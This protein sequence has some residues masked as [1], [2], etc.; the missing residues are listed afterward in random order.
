MNREFLELYNR[1]LGILKEE[2]RQFAA[3]FPGVAERLGGLLEN[4]TDP[5]IAGLL[6]GTAYLASRVQLKLKH[7]YAEFTDNLLDQLV[8]DYLAPVPSAALLRVEP[9]YGDPNLKDGMKIAAGSYADARFVERERRIACKYRLASEIT[10]WPFELGQAEFLSGPATLQALGIEAGP[11]SQAGLRLSLLRRSAADR[12]TEPADKQVA[13][14]PDCWFANCRTDELTFH[15]IG[16]EGDAVRLY[17]QLFGATTGIYVRYLDEAGDP[18]ILPLP[19]SCLAQIGFA[20]DE[21]LFPSDRRVFRGFDLLR[22]YFVLPAKFLGFKLTNLKPVLSAI[23]TNRCDIV[24]AFSQGDS[25]LQSVVRADSFALYAAAASNLFEMQLARVPVKDNEHEYHVVT[26]RSRHLDFEAHRLIRMHAHVTGSGDKMEVYPLYAAPPLGVS[27]TQTM[28]YTVRRLPRRRSQEER[29]NAQ[30][31]QY[32]GSDMFVTLTNHRDRPDGLHVAELSLRA[33]CSNRHLT[34]HLPVGQGGADFILEDKT[35]LRVD[36]VVGPTLPRDSI[37]TD[38]EA[39]GQH[40]AGGTSAWRLI[41]MLS[42]NHLGLSGY[43]TRDSAASLREILSLFAT[44][45]SAAIERRIQG[46]IA[47]DS[48]P[49]TRRIRQRT[50]AGVVRGLEVTVTLDEKHFEGSGI[51]L[52][53]AILDRFLTEF[54]G[55]NNVVETVIRSTERGEIMRWPAQL[56]RRQQL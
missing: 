8:P 14:R 44:R 21:P 42:L 33:L 46:V 56:G 18:V 2:A 23:R 10:L 25:R 13:Q 26:D 7:E 11:A 30:P 27:A 48:R 53:G 49:I 29:R 45:G 31:T 16:Q 15:I 22:E 32:V 40:G 5:M 39:R 17:E 54:V 20:P 28:F 51:F 41:S 47:V 35:T 52:L 9:P 37:A 12:L 36:C 19:R 6:E 3:E 4:N 43:G 34:E 1:E 55:L 38:P 50:G 24:I